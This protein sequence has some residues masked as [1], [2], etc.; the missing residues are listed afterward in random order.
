MMS[1]AMKLVEDEMSAIRLEMDDSTGDPEH[2][3]KL[4]NYLAGLTKARETVKARID[5][6]PAIGNLASLPPG[7]DKAVSIGTLFLIYSF[8]HWDDFVVFAKERM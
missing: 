5:L 2:L 1:K 7:I 3:K 4:A 6:N 8:K